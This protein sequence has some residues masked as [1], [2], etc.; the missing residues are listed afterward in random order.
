MQ[1]YFYVR[2]RASAAEW[3]CQPNSWLS[4]ELEL[5]EIKVG[6]LALL[7]TGSF[8]AFLTC[9]IYNGGY[10]SVYYDW[11]E[12]GIAW[13]FLQFPVVFLYQVTAAT[14]TKTESIVLPPAPPP[15]M[16]AQLACCF[17]RIT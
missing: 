4:T 17:C 9:W 14:S 6:S 7:V 10:S 8:S 3:K 5:H 16:G 13:L 1:W 15:K 12:Y 2:Q 11:N